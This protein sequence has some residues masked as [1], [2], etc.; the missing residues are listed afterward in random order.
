VRKLDFLLQ[1]DLSEIARLEG[2]STLLPREGLLTFFYDFKHQPWGF[3]PATAA[4]SRVVLV[5]D[6]G[7]SRAVVSDPEYVLT[8]AGMRFRLAETL[9]HIGSRAWDALG[10][11]RDLSDKYFDLVSDF[12]RSF[13]P[14]SSGLHRLFGHSANVQGDMQLEAQLVSNGLYCGDS[15]GYRD[16]RRE[17][18]ERGADDWILLLQ[19]DSDDGAELMWGDMGMLY[20]WI[21]RDDLSERRFDRAWMALQCG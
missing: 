8:P 5:P 14:R 15:S 3:D 9:P 11:D 2:P 19:L 21:K 6:A 4:G 12:E 17:A 7:V 20:F 13:Y 1:I 18:L 10:L 16:P